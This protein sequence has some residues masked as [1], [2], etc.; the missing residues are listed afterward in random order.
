MLLQIHILGEGVIGRAALTMKHQ[1]ISSDAVESFGGFELDQDNFELNSHFSAGIKTISVIPVEQLGVVQFG[2]FHKLPESME[3]VEQTKALFVE[4]GNGGHIAREDKSL[5]SS[6]GYL[7]GPGEEQPMETMLPLTNLIW[8][9]TSTSFNGRIELV[10]NQI[11]FD[12]CIQN[13]QPHQSFL[14]SASYIN[15][16]TDISP[17]SSLWNSDEYAQKSSLQPFPSQTVS[18][19]NQGTTIGEGGSFHLANNLQDSKNSFFC[20]SDWFN[21]MESD[22]WLN[23]SDATLHGRISSH[24]SGDLFQDNDISNKL[25][26]LFCTMPDQCDELLTGTLNKNLSHDIN[27]NSLLSSCSGYTRK[28]TECNPSTSIE[29]SISNV[30]ATVGNKKR[31]AMSGI[32]NLLNYPGEDSGCNRSEHFS[33]SISRGHVDNSGIGSTCI[34]R[35]TNKLFTSL[36]INNFLDDVSSS[37]CSIAKSSIEDQLSSASKRRRIDTPLPR[38]ET[39]RQMNSIHSIYNPNKMINVESKRDVIH[40]PLSDSSIC[41]SFSIHGGKVSLSQ[42]QEQPAEKPKKK[43]KPGIRPR[44]KDRQQ[45]HD[46]LLDLRKLIPNADKLSID[47]LL[48]RTIK[49]LL[50]LQSVS[51]HAESIKQL[52]DSED[53]IVPQDITCTRDSGV[54]WAC[55]VGDQAMVCPLIVED[56]NTPGQMSIEIQCE[57]HASFLE[58]VDIIRGFGLAILKGVM[59]A[60]K[61]KMCARFTVATEGKNHVTRHEIFSSLVQLLQFTNPSDQFN[62]GGNGGVGLFNTCQQSAIQLPV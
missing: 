50:F 1:F 21:G 6:C 9:F 51:E 8:P 29:S 49:H 59:E 15:N 58:I 19:N 46:R 38:S 14:P 20:T 18:I 61:A 7:H 45:I 56:L 10:D 55:E 16:A 60:Q 42:Q 43:S 37:S 23:S 52:T 34:L 11:N 22:H 13:I 54:T 44:P 5:I 39:E 41:D 26:Q 30:F 35:P 4:L 24:C 57:E 32:G 2:S 17:C 62:N 25:P 47:C 12:G 40:R 3:F 48:H 27:E 28:V 31:S 36:G 33:D 53:R